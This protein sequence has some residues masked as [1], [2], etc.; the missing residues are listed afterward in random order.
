M[1]A[2]IK[3]TNMQKEQYA[4]NSL[5]DI[6]NFDFTYNCGQKFEFERQMLL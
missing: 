5:L 2:K 6:N 3:E 1:I 4:S